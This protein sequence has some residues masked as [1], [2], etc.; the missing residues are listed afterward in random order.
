VFFGICSQCNDAAKAFVEGAQ[1]FD[2]I[3]LAEHHLTRPQCDAEEQRLRRYG[4]RS[5]HSWTPAT[6]SRRAAVRPG[7]AERREGTPCWLRR[8]DLNTFS[9]PPD[10]TGEGAFH[11]QLSDATVTLIRLRHG[12]FA[13]ISCYLDCS[14]GLVGNNGTKLGNILRV[15]RSLGVP[16]IIVGDFNCTPDEMAPSRW[17]QALKCKILAPD[18]DLTCASGKGRIPDY[19]L[20]SDSARPYIKSV[21]VVRQ[22]PWGPHLG[23]RIQLAARPGEV[24]ARIPW[25]PRRFEIPT[26][27]TQ[28]T[29]GIKR[30]QRDRQQY[31]N[32]VEEGLGDD[33]L[34]NLQHLVSETYTKKHHAFCDDDAWANAKDYAAQS[35]LGQLPPWVQSSL[36]YRA[37]PDCADS[38]GDR[39]GYW[40]MAAEKMLAYLCEVKPRDNARRDQPIKYVRTAVTSHL[41]HQP[42]HQGAAR[43][44]EVNMW[45]TL[46]GRLTGLSKVCLMTNGTSGQRAAIEHVIILTCQQIRD[47]QKLT[48]DDPSEDS[49][50]L[51]YTEALVRGQRLPVP[52]DEQDEWVATVEAVRQR[53]DSHNKKAWQEARPAVRHWTE[54]ALQ[55]SMVEGHG[56]FSKPERKD[57]SEVTIDPLDGHPE[58]DLQEGVNL[59]RAAWGRRWQR[60]TDSQ[61]LQAAMEGLRAKADAANRNRRPCELAD[62]DKAVRQFKNSTGRGTDQWSPAELAA[63]PTPA[64]HELT[65]LINDCEATLSW[66]HQFYHVWY[67]LLRKNDSAVAGEERPIGRF[68]ILVRVWGRLTKHEVGH[69]CDER[70]AFWDAAVAGSSALQAFIVAACLDEAAARGHSAEAWASLFLDLEKFYDNINLV[71]LIKKADALEYPPVELYVCTLMYVAPRVARASGP[72]GA[73]LV[74]C[75][76][77]VAGC[78]HAN[79]AARTM[80]YD[81]LEL[82]HRTAPKAWPRQYVDEVQI[83]AEGACSIVGHQIATS[84]ASIIR[85]CEAD[86]LPISG[87]SAVVAS[88]PAVRDAVGATAAAMGLALA[89]AEIMKGL[90]CD[91]TIGRRRRRATQAKR[92]SQ[93]RQ[94]KK[95]A[96]QFLRAARWRR[97][98]ASLYRTSIRANQ[99][100][101]QAATGMTPHDIIRARAEAADMAGITA[102]HR[103]TA[104]AKEPLT[105]NVTRQ[106][107][108]WV[109]MWRRNDDLRGHLRE[110]WHRVQIHLNSVTKRGRWMAAT[111]P[112]AA[113]QLSLGILGWKGQE[114]EQWTDHRGHTWQISDA[115]DANLTEVED[116][117]KDAATSLLW[118]QRPATDDIDHQWV[119]STAALV[120]RARAVKDDPLEHA[121]WVRGILPNEIC[122]IDPPPEW[123]SLDDTHWAVGN[124]GM[125][126]GDTRSVAAAVAYADGSVT[127]GDKRI[128]RAGWGIALELPED[129]GIDIDDYPGWFSIVDGPQTVA[130]AELAAI[131]WTLKLTHGPLAI[132]TDSQMVADGWRSYSYAHPEGVRVFH[133]RKQ[134]E[135]A[136]GNRM[137]KRTDG[138]WVCLECSKG[139]GKFSMVDWMRTHGRNAMP[140]VANSSGRAT[141]VPK[142]EYATLMNQGPIHPT[143]N[144]SYLHG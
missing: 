44:P 118:S 127:S 29:K 68:P 80:L 142:T 54:Q 134:V 67:Q 121:F 35:Q 83:R 60:D 45:G 124:F 133:T 106:L 103:C 20:Y 98:S 89:Q 9:H 126:T 141:K 137:H 59:R 56:Y 82:A 140:M 38:L 87:K 28:I 64:R 13:L 135:E 143:H 99:Q 55:G 66:P 26:V 32:A 125:R 95:R 115:V 19:L 3:G 131:Y 84:A 53:A 114:A 18:A 130:A 8:N 85:S 105:A 61:D 81:I 88:H 36:A 62:L 25:L 52:D 75:N 91:T 22:V 4:W 70:A 108:E 47:A 93:A 112:M 79:N 69:W 16:W 39:Y 122:P 72:Y 76:S 58:G 11:D 2:L 33:E 136:T 94:R 65:D 78:N 119:T 97:R 96:K 102:G 63:L 107:R 40:A 104:T 34:A 43:R 6:S 77:I 5:M 111:G 73:P 144:L 92:A 7:Q 123:G 90:G 120:A 71:K 132:V 49:R 86:Q 117:I 23:L 21:D 37:N 46:Q 116:A 128:A 57:L 129:T 1:C 74:P 24:Q 10:K 110:A 100:H 101:D 138:K 48:E 12:T 42:G 113:L 109:R 15:T 30:A 14:I 51:R 17:P 27:E 50:A 31:E 139:P 41:K